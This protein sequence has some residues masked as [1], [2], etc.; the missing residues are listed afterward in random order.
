MR[1]TLISIPTLSASTFSNASFI[2]HPS[3]L[4]HH[5]LHA[6]HLSH[7]F[8]PP[9]CASFFICLHLPHCCS[10]LCHWLSLVVEKCLNTRNR[11]VL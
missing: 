7:V 8:V 3:E 4:F 11:P 1:R 5:F 10:S 2:K 9:A 6:A